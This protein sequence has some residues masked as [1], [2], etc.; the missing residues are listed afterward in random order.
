MKLAV[1]ATALCFLPDGEVGPTLEETIPGV[2]EDRFVAFGGELF[3]FLPDVF[4]EFTSQKMG[5]VNARGL[6]P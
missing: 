6:A 3:C 2:L 4:P 5:E 1:G